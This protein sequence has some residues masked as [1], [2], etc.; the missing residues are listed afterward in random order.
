MLNVF[1][2]GNSPVFQVFLGARLCLGPRVVRHALESVL[3][4]CPMM[5]GVLGDQ[6]DLED[7]VDQDD[8]V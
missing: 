1:H 6:E 8:P 5:T 3:P 7:L 4:L 2:P